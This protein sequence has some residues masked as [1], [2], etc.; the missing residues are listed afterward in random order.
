MLNGL[1]GTIAYPEVLELSK[2]ITGVCQTCSIFMKKHGL[3]RFQFNMLEYLQRRILLPLHC[4]FANEARAQPIF[5]YSVKVSLDT[6]AAIVSFDSDEKFAR[7]MTVAGGMFR[8]GIR[9]A[10]A[11][12]AME[13]LAQSQS[14][15]LSR[16]V[17]N[18]TSATPFR[19]LTHHLN[20]QSL[21]RIK[22]GETNVKGPMFL[23]MVMTQ[24]EGG[25]DGRPLR[26]R[27]AEAA[28]DS[29]QYCYD[30]LK[31]RKAAQPPMDNMDM[32]ETSTSSIGDVDGFD[33]DFDLDFFMPDMS[34]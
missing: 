33:F 19:N 23:S 12:I 3:P 1:R 29:L 15:S 20:D 26:L 6:A 11:T 25:E 9:Y 30:L 17:D 16:E 2:Q 24:A 28:R 34:L 21:E 5:Y 10:Y 27:T 13:V 22:K 18:A 31:V 32:A 7:L 4:L 14:H 8:E